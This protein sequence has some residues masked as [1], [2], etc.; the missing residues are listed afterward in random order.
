MSKTE[1]LKAEILRQYKSVRQFAMAVAIP[2]STIVTALDRGIDGM[3]YGSVIRICTKLGLNPIDF[4][5][6]EKGDDLS[7]K[8]VENRVMKLYNGLNRSGR[9]K[10]LD[11]MSDLSENEKYREVH[12][13]L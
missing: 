3:S 11:Y 1:T 2:Y 12:D 8:I 4:T 5:R 6:L 7:E 9:R 13:D 10:A